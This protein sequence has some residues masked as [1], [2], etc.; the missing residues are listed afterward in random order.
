MCDAAMRS[1]NAP[2]AASTAGAG[3]GKWYSSC[4]ASQHRYAQQHRPAHRII[5][6]RGVPLLHAPAPVPGNSSTTQLP[7]PPLCWP[8]CLSCRCMR[9]SLSGPGSTPTR[10]R[11]RERCWQPSRP[12]T[13]QDCRAR[14]VLLGWHAVRRT[15]S[16]DWAG[17]LQPTC[18][19]IGVYLSCLSQRPRPKA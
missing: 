11:W 16:A 12:A 1:N 9:C 17:Q 13:E 19:V 2:A 5:Y 18:R 15:M 14:W 6:G 10:A 4:T 3:R 8:C 7:P